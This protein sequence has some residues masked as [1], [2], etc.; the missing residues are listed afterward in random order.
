[1]EQY[2]VTYLTKKYGLRTLVIEQVRA[3]IKAVNAYADVD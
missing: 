1:M 2:L 3:F